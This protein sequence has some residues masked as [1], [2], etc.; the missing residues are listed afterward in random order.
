VVQRYNRPVVLRLIEKKS[1]KKTKI[2]V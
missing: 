1:R 2:E